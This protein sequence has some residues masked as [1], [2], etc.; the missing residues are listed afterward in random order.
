MVP[1]VREVLSAQPA[2]AWVPVAAV[3]HQE[4]MG[5]PA[6][7]GRAD[8]THCAGL[9]GCLQRHRQSCRGQQIHCK[10][11]TKGGKKIWNKPVQP[12]VSYHG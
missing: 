12:Y 2:P 5:N 7:G 11:T 6:R 8:K 3:H 1:R 9:Q 10:E 4:H